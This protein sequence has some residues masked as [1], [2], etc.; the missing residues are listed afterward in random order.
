MRK[1][2]FWLM[3]MLCL[4]STQSW[5]GIADGK[6]IICH[7]INCSIITEERGW[8]FN[9]GKVTY[10]FPSTYQD[11]VTIK[12]Q[13]WGSYYSDEKTIRWVFGGMGR[14]LDR[15]TLIITDTY[16]NP[17]EKSRCELFQSLSEFKK[18]WQTIKRRLQSEYNSKLKKNKI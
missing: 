2:R 10:V 9:D 14:I 3:I 11:K 1:I 12:E 18:K 7:C 4:I 5:S 13:S 6:S 8:A 15:S 16:S 17:H